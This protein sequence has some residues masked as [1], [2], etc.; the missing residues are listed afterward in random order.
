MPNTSGPVFITGVGL[1][2]TLGIGV[3]EHLAALESEDAAPRRAVGPFSLEDYLPSKKPLLD[4]H[5][6]LGLLAAALAL[7]EAAIEG[8][9]PDPPRSDL[10]VS[11]EFGNHHSLA[12]FRKLIRDK[13]VRLA[14]PILFPHTYL[15]TTAS[16]IAIE[17]GLR[18]G[19]L[20]F[21]DGPAGTIHG[22]RL[23][24]ERLRSGE[25]SLALV[26][27]VDYVPPEREADPS[28][29]EGAAFL[30]LESAAGRAARGADALCELADMRHLWADAP[31]PEAGASG[32]ADAVFAA[33]DAARPDAG[34]RAAA[35]QRLAGD[36]RAA[37]LPLA[38]GLAALCCHSGRLPRRLGGSGT[39]EEIVVAEATPSSKAVLRIRAAR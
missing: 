7:G 17:F 36:C 39:C 28:L 30:V 12:A 25:A 32:R 24:W 29:T 4:R 27:G 20:C 34:Q 21:C 37:R 2:S 5:S 26:G 35:L 33:S 23:A 22:L 10:A 1:V 14:S 13:G 31:L 6:A 9:V 3:E 8:R 38:A 19:H 15:N 18:G 16:L 11:T